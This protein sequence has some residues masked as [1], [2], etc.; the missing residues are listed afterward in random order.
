MRVRSPKLILNAT[1]FSPINQQKHQRSRST[2]PYYFDV[3]AMAEPNN[4][5]HKSDATG[6]AVNEA[7]PFDGNRTHVREHTHMRGESEKLDE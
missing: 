7:C 5:I 4:D 6:T 3:L 1:A 2:T